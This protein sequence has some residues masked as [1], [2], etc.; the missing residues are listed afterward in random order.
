M[1]CLGIIIWTIYF[2]LRVQY[3]MCVYVYSDHNTVPPFN[4]LTQTLLGIV[5]SRPSSTLL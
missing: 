3:S 1:C 5:T 4:G 2:Q